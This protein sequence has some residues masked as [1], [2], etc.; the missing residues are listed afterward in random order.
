MMIMYGIG[1]VLA[2]LIGCM[3]GLLATAAH[4]ER[5]RAGHGEYEQEIA[6]GRDFLC[7]PVCLQTQHAGQPGGRR[8]DRDLELWVRDCEQKSHVFKPQA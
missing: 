6:E 2:L 3:I 4:Y 1:L 7:G 5:M 8:S